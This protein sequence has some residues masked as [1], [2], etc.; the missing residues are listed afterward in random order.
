[1]KGGGAHSAARPVLDIRGK[2]LATAD[3]TPPLS[4]GAVAGATALCAV[5]RMASPSE[6]A[7]RASARTAIDTRRAPPA[8]S[9]ALEMLEWMWVSHDREYRGAV[10]GMLL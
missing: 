5:G 9:A 7:K 8:C 4:D 10:P 2:I 3:E 1:M 6:R